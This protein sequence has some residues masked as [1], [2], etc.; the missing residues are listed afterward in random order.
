MGHRFCPNC[1][2]ELDDD[3]TYCVQCVEERY[4]FIYLLYR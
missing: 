4:L 3:D 1:G 2:W